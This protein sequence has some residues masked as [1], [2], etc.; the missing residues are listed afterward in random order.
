MDSKSV[1]RKDVSVRFRQGPQY[2]M[3]VEEMRPGRGEDRVTVVRL[4]DRTIFALA[5]GAGGVAGGGAAASAVCAAV[6]GCQK[7]GKPADWAKWL[8]EIDRTMAL[9]PSSGLAAVV[10]IEVVDDGT[11]VGASVGDCEAWSF[12][13]DGAAHQ[14]TAEQIRKPL[15]GSGHASPIAFS[16]RMAGRLVLASDGLWKYMAR[17]QI[18]KAALVQSLDDAIS[19]LV[20]GVR[21]RSGALQDDVSVIACEAMRA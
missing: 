5:D 7:G 17:G 13:S 8:R 11:V 21:L 19:G 1:V 18:V 20:S 9:L 4:L 16:S 3:T 2:A 6:D 14:L 10:V 12:G 15:L